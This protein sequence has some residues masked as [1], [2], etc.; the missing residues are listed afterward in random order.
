MG[1]LALPCAALKEHLKV[2]KLPS[3]FQERKALL[4]GS[5]WSRVDTGKPQ[6][7]GRGHHMN[8]LPDETEDTFQKTHL[9]FHFSAFIKLSSCFTSGK[10]MTVCATPFPRLCQAAPSRQQWLRTWRTAV[11][12]LSWEW[13]GAT[14][15]TP[16][17][18]R[19]VCGEDSRRGVP[20]GQSAFSV[21]TLGLQETAAEGEGG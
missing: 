12:A 2:T 7:L 4:P 14:S 13:G 18:E 17:R 21:R 15:P 10:G 16:G 5:P 8:P 20:E 9:N 6:P 11:A 1:S 19:H 3:Q